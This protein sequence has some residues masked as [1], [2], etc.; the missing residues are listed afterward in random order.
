[1]TTIV[2]RSGKGT[3]LTYAEMDANL[4]NLNTYVP[5]GTGAVAT[6]VQA[7]L[8]ESVS[9][10]DFG[11]V[12]DGVTDDTAAIQA[13]IDHVSSLGGGTVN[14]YGRHL[15]DTNLTINDSV[16]LCGPLKQP[17][18]LLP[19]TSADYDGKAGVL[20]VNSA[21]TITIRDSAAV[22]NCMVIR[23]GLDLPFADV[24]AATAG[25]AAFA[26]TAFTVGGAD[27]YFGHMLI[28]GFNLAIS[29]S[30]YERIRCEY[31]QGDCTNG[32]RLQAVY[33]ISYIENCHFWPW[34]TTHQSWTT[35]TLLTRSGKAFEYAGDNDWGKFTNCFS[36][37]YAQGFTVTGCDHVN[38]VG[39]GADYPG[40]GF[41]ASSVTGFTINGD[42]KEALLLGCQSAAQGVG[43]L[44]NTNA[45]LK[46][47]HRIIGHNSWDGTSSHITIQS[48]S[49][50]IS[51]CQLSG[52]SGRA[53]LLYSGTTGTIVG[54]DISSIGIGIEGN[55]GWDYSLGW[56]TIGNYASSGSPT[57]VLTNHFSNG[58]VSSR[59]VSKSYATGTGEPGFSLYRP[60]A[61]VDEKNW[62]IYV[63]S[64][65][66]DL[67]IRAFTDDFSAGQ[68]AL[69]AARGAGAT[70]SELLLC[71]AGGNRVGVGSGGMLP[72]TDN[73]YTLGDGS[74]RYSVVYAATGT[75]NTSDEREKKDIADSSLG[76]S[77]INALR[78]VSYKWKV[79][80]YDVE[81]TD[82]EKVQIAHPVPGTRTH[83][84][85]I[86]QEVKAATDAAGVDFA[87]WTMDD[88]SDP[89]SRQGL[90]YDQFIAPLIK[91]VQELS[92]EVQILKSKFPE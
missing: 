29:S 55:A 77:F 88:P 51:N 32:I 84:G 1:M 6:T 45:A 70:V 90:R 53:I 10:K 3:A 9:V 39:C 11:A 72:K 89:E 68:T 61:P 92:T 24:T 7:K 25:V 35:S 66:E 57:N 59:G 43:V 31:V 41:A 91:A 64:A 21:A 40:G 12:G 73:A 33:D 80:R 37:G 48:G 67:N 63:T 47:S 87:G 20:L 56:N 42:S 76:L 19:S 18:E 34:T 58:A 75:I 27:A 4:T 5:A 79:G 8:R 44:I 50:T 46:N 26:G 15:I 65:N 28:L 85:L 86:A 49:T 16:W 22:T 69:I 38:I 60:D 78:P 17:G 62:R 30:N 74:F 14:F 23:K 83:W 13:A 81:T 82:D 36:Y 71:A 54:C 52:G 2:T